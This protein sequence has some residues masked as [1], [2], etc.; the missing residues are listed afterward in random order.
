MNQCYCDYYICL[1]LFFAIILLILLIIIGKHI[2]F[3]LVPLQP[4][5]VLQSLLVGM[6]KERQIY[7]LDKHRLRVNINKLKSQVYEENVDNSNSNGP[8]IISK[9]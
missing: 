9:K 7:C 8:Q 3:T 5:V 4:L 2:I 6:L 1:C